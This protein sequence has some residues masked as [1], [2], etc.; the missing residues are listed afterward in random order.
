MTVSMESLPPAPPP[1]PTPADEAD[2]AEFDGLLDEAVQAVRVSADKWRTG[3]AALVTLATTALLVQGPT[4]AADLAGGFRFLVVGLLAA[5]LVV[6]IFG[7]WWALSAAS[8]VPVAV[9]YPEIRDKYSS[10]KAFKVAAAT[11][12]AQQLRKALKAVAVSLG[13]FLGG[14][15]C[16]WLAPTATPSITVVSPAGQVCGQLDSADNQAFRIVV[17]GESTP[18]HIRFDEVTN[19]TV[20]TACG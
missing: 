9:S 7:L 12:A 18:R 13:L 2:R 3:L 17:K 8:G 15:V 20:V 10:V 11:D 14:M 4:S 19:V 5:G 1:P 6:A 16:W